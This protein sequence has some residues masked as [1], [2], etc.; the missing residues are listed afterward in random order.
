MLSRYTLFA[1]VGIMAGWGCHKA[2]ELPPV[3]E[4]LKNIQVMDRDGQALP[5][6]WVVSQ[7]N[8]VD[9][10]I[11]FEAVEP[12]TMLGERKVIPSDQW[13]IVMNALDENDKSQW[14]G[15]FRNKKEFA[16][17]RI[18]DKQGQ[19]VW[20]SPDTPKTLPQGAIWQWCHCRVPEPGRYKLVFKL[21]P[22]VFQMPNSLRIDYGEGIELARQTLIVEPGEKLEGSLSVS[23]INGD[24]LNRSMYRRARAKQK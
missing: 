10:T 6:E 8:P 5:D 13:I 21:Y 23:I 17:E 1:I 22:T 14:S 11:Q 20:E 3:T 9:P 19:L 16:E 24:L 7:A 2:P 12:P 4:F 18:G 15:M